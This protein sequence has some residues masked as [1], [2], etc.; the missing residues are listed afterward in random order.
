MGGPN[1]SP[2]YVCA[3]C[4]AFAACP[5]L[6]WNFTPDLVL[7]LVLANRMW[8]KWLC[9]CSEPKLK[10]PCVLLLCLQS[11]DLSVQTSLLEDE[12]PC[13]GEMICCNWATLPAN[14]LL[15]CQLMQTH[16]TTQLTQ[17]IPDELQWAGSWVTI[18]GFVFSYWVSGQD[19]IQQ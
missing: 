2:S 3:F 6:G 11:C 12:L 7:W 1:T 18:N 13:A 10:R 16:E 14:L 8:Y 9:T 15:T 17:P 19:I 4:D 5:I